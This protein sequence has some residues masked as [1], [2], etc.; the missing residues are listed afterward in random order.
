MF[1]DIVAKGGNLLLIVNLDGQGALPELQEKRLIDIGKWLKVNGEGIYSTRPFTR[2]IDGKVAF[3]C[4]K[5]SQYVYTIMKEWP[6]QEQ[7]L[8]G[9][10]PAR[11]SKIEMLGYN[12]SLEWISSTEGITVKFPVQLQ[13]EK[14]RPCEHAWIM[15]IKIK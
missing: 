3:T 8:R 11:G 1:V 12:N 13:N 5:D 7:H 6:G 2:Q 9:I 10:K 4:S 14:S 15:K